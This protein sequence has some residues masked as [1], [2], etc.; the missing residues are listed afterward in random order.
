MYIR[1]TGFLHHLLNIDSLAE[2]DQHPIRGLSW[3]TFVLEDLIRREAIHHPHTLF[4]FWRTAIGAEIDLVLD[5]GS[6]R[7][8]IEVTVGRGDR[9]EV[10]RAVEQAA[11]DLQADQTWIVAQTPGTEPLRPTV[12]H[13]GIPDAFEWL[14]PNASG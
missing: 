5:P 9:A 3:E 7:I 11:R 10:T 4:Y 14:P 6:S 1:D 13:I 2:L 8:A 12:M